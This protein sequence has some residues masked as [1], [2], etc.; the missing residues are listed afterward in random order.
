MLVVG[1]VVVVMVVFA[2]PAPYAR[3]PG[4]RACALLVAFYLRHCPAPPHPAPLFPAGSTLTP[5]ARP[6]QGS[7]LNLGAVSSGA[8]V[9]TS[10]GSTLN[11]GDSGRDHDWC[12]WRW[13]VVLGSCGC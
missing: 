13:V 11:P 2:F 12:C 5:R 1:V 7:T 10:S 8:V 6:R 4:F 3:A 9:S